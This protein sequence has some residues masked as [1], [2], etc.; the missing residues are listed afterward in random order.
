MP[1]LPK[2]PP[3]SGEHPVALVT[4]SSGKLDASK[5]FY[6]RQFGWQMMPM[7][8]ELCACATSAGQA[9]ALRAGNPKGFPAIVPFVAVEDVDQALASALQAGCTVEKAKWTAPLVGALA[10]FTDAAGTIWGLTS[11]TQSKPREPLPTGL[12]DGPKPPVGSVCSIE[13]YAKDF[14]TCARFVREQFGWNTLETMP[15]YMLFDAGA[16]IAG[17]FQSHTPALPAVAYLYVEDVKAKLAA[18]EKAG[19]QRMGD[20]TSMPGMGMFGYFTDP[21]G[22]PMGLIGP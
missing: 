21:T 7:T 11:P 13:L 9:V 2:V 5:E 15:G 8:P 1:G 17:V 3:G 6:A 14:V 18:L 16:G 12:G 10:R 4:I 22:T 19:G 20:P